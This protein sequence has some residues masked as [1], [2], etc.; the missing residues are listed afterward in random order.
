MKITNIKSFVVHTKRDNWVFTRV[1]TDE[2]FT[3]LGES[4]MEGREE[5]VIAA[6]DALKP[7][8]IGKDP[9]DTEL[10]YHQMFRD[11]YWGSCA[12][13]VGA[14]SAIDGALWDIKGKALN[15]PVYQLLGGSFRKKIRVYANRWFFGA[16]RP[17]ELAKKAKDI[18]KQGYTALKWDPFGRAQWEISTAQLDSTLKE[19]QAVREAVGHGVDIMIEGHGRFNQNTALKIARE[20]VPFK[21]FFFEEPIMP[22]NIDALAQLHDKSPIP[23]AAGERFY[24]KTDFAEVLRRNAI[25]Y[26]QPDLRWTGGITEGKKIA[27][28]CEANFIQ[29]APHNIH[30][31]IGVAMTIQLAAAIPNAVILEHSVEEIP[32]LSK[33]VDYQFVVENGYMSI[34]DRP[35]LGID[36][37]EEAAKEFPLRKQSMIENMFESE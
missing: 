13:L 21:P 35:G 6:I 20:M 4:S 10:H 25:D 8:L 34:P 18:V 33:I 3:G 28:I 12:I 11:A 14:L 22:E 29:V 7:Y 17:E 24:T 15:V 32:W 2:G 16:S 31:P 37:D 27:A 36:I 30:G 23:I 26:A 1:Y 9:F 19:I 5:T